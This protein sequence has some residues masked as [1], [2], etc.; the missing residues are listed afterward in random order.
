M[1]FSPQDTHKLMFKNWLF[2]IGLEMLR[3]SKTLFLIIFNHSAFYAAYIFYVGFDLVIGLT[4]W[5]N[6]WMQ[7]TKSFRHLDP[8][9]S[10]H[11]CHI[12]CNCGQID[13]VIKASKDRKPRTDPT[14]K[15][16][17]SIEYLPRLEAKSLIWIWLN[18]NISPPST[19]STPSIY[20]VQYL[21]P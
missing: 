14:P 3:P 12:Y 9:E 16:A 19:T 15:G 5:Q 20:F 17:P 11:N 7:V 21:W 2:F 10:V 4:T 8:I 13:G 18:I 6:Q 1:E